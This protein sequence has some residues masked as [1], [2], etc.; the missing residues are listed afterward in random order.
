MSNLKIDYAEVEEVVTSLQAALGSGESSR[1][2]DYSKM[3]SAFSES[4]GEEA[5]ALREL[6][7]AENGLLSEMNGLLSEFAKSIQFAANEFSNLDSSGA[8]TIG[9][10]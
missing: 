5:D 1:S 6:Q 9:I 10:K 3:I 2:G 7:Q 4:C 8:A